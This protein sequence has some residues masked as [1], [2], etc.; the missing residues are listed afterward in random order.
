MNPSSKIIG[1][2]YQ[3]TTLECW[4]EGVMRTDSDGTEYFW[5]TGRCHS[6]KYVG[7]LPV[8]R[9]DGD[10]LIKTEL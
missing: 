3:G 2:S 1:I 8:V 4:T 10:K 6:G 5:A 7:N 9:L